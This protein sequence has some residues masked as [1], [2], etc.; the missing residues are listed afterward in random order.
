MSPC[1]GV[2][3]RIGLDHA[4]RCR[5]RIAWLRPLERLPPLLCGM[6]RTL[7]PLLLRGML[8]RTL[9]V[10]ACLEARSFNKSSHGAVQEGGPELDLGADSD[11]SGGGG[12]PAE[13][14]KAAVDK[15]LRRIMKPFADG[16]L[17]IPIEVIHQWR[18]VDQRDKVKAVFEK[19]GYDPDGGFKRA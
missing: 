6:W 19:C 3:G 16:T 11:S 15:R 7:T 2:L 1:T 14:S 4:P 5:S 9:R 17:K 8:V 12:P 18:D 10:Q 13:L